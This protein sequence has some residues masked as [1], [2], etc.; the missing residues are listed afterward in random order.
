MADPIVRQVFTAP[1]F[2]G[3]PKKFFER[4]IPEYFTADFY[5]VDKDQKKSKVSKEDLKRLKTI[6]YSLL[7][8]VTDS[9]TVDIVTLSIEGAS[10]YEGHNIITTKTFNPKRISTVLPRHLE[11]FHKYRARFVSVAVQVCLQ[12]SQLKKS[13]D[14]KVTWTLGDKVDI[15]NEELEKIN[16]SL[17]EPTYR[18]LDGSFF[19]E[20]SRL[21]KELVASG[22]RTPIKT[23]HNLYYPEKTIKH[24]Q[25]YATRC[26]KL[27]L[28]PKAEA[29]RN[30][31]V[32]K[33]R[34]R[35]GR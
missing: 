15:S 19:A 33:P 14:G 17:I 4:D 34:K 5:I 23:L 32:R 22:D 10:R 12:T 6:R 24:V 27:G 20:F 1:S 13:K 7:L 3:E 25:S 11:Q 21:Y 28:I 26:R 2:Y 16:E 9:G 8:R 31:D 30:S 35:K 29:G 18:K